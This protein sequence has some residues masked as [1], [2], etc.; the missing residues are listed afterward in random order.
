MKL[1]LPKGMLRETLKMALDSVR[2]HK[3]RS[4]LTVLGIVI[5]V[6]T[7]ICIASLLTGLRQNIVSMIEEYGTNNI[8]AFHLS[9]G[10]RTGED[11]SER[12]RKPLTVADAETIKAQAPA[13]EDV[14]WVAPNVGY[15]GG[16]FDDNITYQGRNYRWGNTSG[17][18]PN[19]DGI[20]NITLKEGRFIT[21]S[22]DQQRSNVMVIGV[23]AAEALFPGQEDRIAGTMVRM[24]GYNFEVVGVLEKRKAGFFGENEED[25]AVY[26]PFRTAQKVAPAK[27]YLLM[28]IRGRTGQV[29]EALNQS[30]EILRRRRLVK[31]GEP[32]NFDIKTADK[33]I[34]QF[35]SITAMVG[36]IAIAIS[37]LGL[38]V[39][40]IGVMNIMLVSV[41][42]RTKEIGV[43]K[44]IGARRRDIVRQFLFE[45]MMLTFLGGVLGVLLAVGASQILMLLIP[46]LPAS[47][48]T[49]AVVTGLT[50][51][52]SVGLI[53]G[54]W[55]ARKASR[56]D[57]IECLRY[58]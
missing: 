32:N 4:F 8:Y 20:T 23:N 55:P 3:F 24:G 39:G 51:S 13:V 37:S 1:Q 19:Y 41:T 49:W 15:G 34:E 29:L 28:V 26:I 47:I 21:E 25:N 2:G 36:L 17:V 16:P 42:E 9:T 14:A 22:D 52:I 44:A 48:P 57:P 43:R 31:F 35:D 11:R 45:A 6:M 18:S 7:A 30:E 53:F 33:F 27:G 50:V 46:S 38:L 12:T 5:G 10:P 56:L 54:V 40:G 58:E